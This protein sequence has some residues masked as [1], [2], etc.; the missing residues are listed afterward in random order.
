MDWFLY[1]IG[2]GHERVNH[3][4]SLEQ[5]HLFFAH[6]LEYLILVLDNNMGEERNNFQIE[7]VQYRLLISKSYQHL[8]HME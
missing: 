5:T 1:D 8:Q 3:I 7:K 4:I 2:L 6:L